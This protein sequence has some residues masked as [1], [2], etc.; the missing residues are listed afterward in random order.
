MGITAAQKVR[1]GVFVV[2]GMIILAAFII[3]PVGMK[4]SQRNVTFYAFFENES[5]MGLEQG[6]SVKFNGVNIGRVER[7]SYYPEDINKMKVEMSISDQFPM[8]VDMYAYTALIGI[9]GLKCIEI[10]G[11]SNDAQALRAGGEIRTRPT[12]FATIGD[13]VEVFVGKLDTLFNHL[14]AITNPDSLRSVKIALDNIADL[15][16]DAKGV[17]NDIRAVIPMAIEVV[18]TVQ[19]AADEVARITRDVK[20]MTEMIKSG[21]SDGNIPGLIA[22]VDTTIAS[23]KALT[24]NL[25]LTVMQTREDLSVSMENLREA[26]ESANQ[27]MRMLSENPSLLIRGEARERDRR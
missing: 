12:L 6:A 9:T 24:D 8:K 2:I 14:N 7:V 26:L 19:S 13:R 15:T 27:L 4:M 16:G 22:H 10:S 1:L 18:D 11:G 25:S 5:L 20:E 17:F 23:V 3:V 21:I